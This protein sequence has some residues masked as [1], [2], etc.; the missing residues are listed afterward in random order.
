VEF[1]FCVY[2]AVIPSMFWFFVLNHAH[3]TSPTIHTI[4]KACM[5]FRSLTQRKH[6]LQHFHPPCPAARRSPPTSNGLL[7]EWL[8]LCLILSRF[9]FNLASA[10]NKCIIYANSFGKLA[11]LVL[12]AIFGNCD[13]ASIFRLIITEQ[14]LSRSVFSRE[15]RPGGWAN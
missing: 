9:C 12:L 11:V 8:V 7:L 2:L 10:S 13:G 3:A 5:S 1:E 15:S 6:S 4:I 14:Q